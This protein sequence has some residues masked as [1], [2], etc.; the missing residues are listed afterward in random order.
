LAA[1]T[2][3]EV[4]AKF[5]D[6]QDDVRRLIDL[7]DR[8]LALMPEVAAWKWRASQ[9]VADIDRERL[10]L[11]KT[12]EQAREFGLDEE[13]AR[14]F[15]AVQIRLAREVQDHKFNEWHESNAADLPRSRD[16][17]AEIRPALD[18]LGNQILVAAYLASPFLHRAEYRELISSQL[19]HLRQHNGLSELGAAELQAALTTLSR[20]A[21]ISLDTI[22][23]VGILRVG[24]TGDYAPFSADDKGVLTGFDVHLASNL[25]QQLGVTVQFVHTSWA[26]L[27]TDLKHGDF[28]LAMS[29]IS[30]TAERADQADFSTAYHLDGKTPISRCDD[31]PRFES[32]EKIDQPQVRVIVNPGGT[33]ERFVRERLKRARIV[34]HADNRSVFDELVAGRADVMITDG[35]EVKL[36]VMRHPNLCGTMNAPMT[37]SPKAI[38]LPLH[39]QLTPIINSWLESQR[40][41]GALAKQLQSALQNSR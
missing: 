14:N 34:V 22:K 20:G 41:N 31:A 36:Q 19:T 6:P 5:I 35:I 2:H 33:N 27:L 1:S 39:S 18:D 8:R 11:Q 13:S 38:M 26:S 24:M 3:A 32:L 7:I 28:D 4:P 23:R 16:L 15:F 17:N 37:Q 30:I 10:V 12:V 9:P 40:A 29:G 21:A 25:A